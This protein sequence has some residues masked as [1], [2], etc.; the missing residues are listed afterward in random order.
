M[1]TNVMFQSLFHRMRRGTAVLGLVLLASAADALA[2]IVP[3]QM[4]G[5]YAPV[6]LVFVTDGKVAYM[7]SGVVTEHPKVL[8]TCAHTIYKNRWLPASQIGFLPGLHS[9]K[10]PNVSAVR[11][12]GYYKFAN[13]HLAKSFNEQRTMDILAAF[14]YANMAGGNYSRAWGANSADALKSTAISKVVVGYPH[15]RSK[16][17]Y[18]HKVGQAYFKFQD[19]VGTYMWL[20]G[21]TTAHG[22]SGGPVFAFWDQWYVAGV[23]ITSDTTWMGVRALDA[24]A[25]QLLSLAAS[26][27]GH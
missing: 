8:L 14:G 11:V 18:Q 4:S 20:N 10:L 15:E 7:G 9:A 17:F 3:T 26:A 23:Q 19:Y 6:G 27:A 2:V 16:N 13:Y 25:M 12:R 24:Q 1:K 5:P 22:N 21:A